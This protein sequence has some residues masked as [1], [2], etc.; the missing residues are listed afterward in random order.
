MGSFAFL[1][2]GTGAGS[3]TLLLADAVHGVGSFAVLPPGTGAGTIT[4]VL[5]DVP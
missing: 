4:L 1:P 2:P 5:A 3:I